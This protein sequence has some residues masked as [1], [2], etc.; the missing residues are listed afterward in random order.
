MFLSLDG[1]T[2]G[3]HTTDGA[4]TLAP[5][6]AEAAAAATVGADGA[7]AVALG[8]GTFGLA[9]G[10]VGWEVEGGMVRGAANL[11]EVLPT[12]A[13]HAR[14]A[15]FLSS[16]TSVVLLALAAALEGGCWGGWGDGWG[17]AADADADADCDAEGSEGASS[18]MKLIKDVLG[19]FC[20]RT[21][22]ICLWLFLQPVPVT[23]LSALLTL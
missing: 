1:L 23:L 22:L 11:F 6:L 19:L 16:L 10:L 14:G 15:C 18:S 3:R 9:G 20:P 21:I 12:P 17:R 4:L 8:C 7:G 2:G 5:A 13:R